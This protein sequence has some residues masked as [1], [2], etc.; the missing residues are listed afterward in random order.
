MVNS[1]PRKA[2]WIP[3]ADR[4]L[5]PCHTMRGHI[6]GDIAGILLQYSANCAVS[7][8]KIALVLARGINN[9]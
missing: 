5:D 4:R 7:C 6:F 3:L 9:R 8:H 2:L 1:L